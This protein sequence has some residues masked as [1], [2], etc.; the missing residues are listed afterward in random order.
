MP[1]P[2][3]EPNLL[4]YLESHGWSRDSVGRWRHP[5]VPGDAHADRAYDLC[6]RWECLAR[7]EF[8]DDPSEGDPREDPNDVN[9]RGL[10]PS[11]RA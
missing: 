8:F 2:P 5:D 9:T 7:D 10:P 3:T 11:H 6:V 1:G 4:A